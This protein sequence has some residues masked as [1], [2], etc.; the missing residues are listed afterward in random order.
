MKRA[1]ELRDSFSHENSLDALHYTHASESLYSIASVVSRC[2]HCKPP[3]L[4]TRRSKDAA[5]K[6]VLETPQQTGQK[7]C[8]SQCQLYL[9]EVERQAESH[10]DIQDVCVCIYIP[11]LRIQCMYMCRKL[12]IANFSEHPSSE[13]SFSHGRR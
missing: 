10:T 12:R 8:P 1:V 13:P 9:L 3:R 4:T 7:M 6:S 11:T 5:T 2:K